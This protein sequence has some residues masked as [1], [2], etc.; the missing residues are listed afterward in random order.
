MIAANIDWP[1]NQGLAL[2]LTDQSIANVRVV[3]RRKTPP[4]WLE[5]AVVIS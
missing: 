4:S 3:S 1:F 5:G 2:E